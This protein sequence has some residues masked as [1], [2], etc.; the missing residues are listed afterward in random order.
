MTHG[1]YCME[2]HGPGGTQ[3]ITAAS[4]ISSMRT[5]PQPYSLGAKVESQV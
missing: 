3:R 1:E 5:A 4:H 2:R